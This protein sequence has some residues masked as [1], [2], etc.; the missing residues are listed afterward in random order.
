MKNIYEIN[1]DSG[2]VI[3]SCRDLIECHDFVGTG[4]SYLF[5]FIGVSTTDIDLKF[6]GEAYSLKSDKFEG[7]LDFDF[8]VQKLIKTHDVIYIYLNVSSGMYEVGAL[9]LLKIREDDNN[10][11]WLDMKASLKKIYISSS[12]IYSGFLSL[13]DKDTVIIEGKYIQD[14][15]SF[16]CELGYALFGK[17]GYIGNNLN[18][19]SDILNDLCQDGREINIIW[20]DSELSFK[21]IDNTVPEGYYQSSSDYM[22]ITIEEYCNLV[23]E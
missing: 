6:N 23:L 4:Y 22:V 13:L 1:D 8:S 17:F 20:K 9:S 11:I 16:Y 14:Y 10:R 12:Y 2:Q 5:A 15:Y 7:R 21:A 3:F 18:A 19:V